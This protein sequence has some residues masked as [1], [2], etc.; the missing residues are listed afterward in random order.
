MSRQNR[1]DPEGR[2]VAV[3]ARG[4]LMGNRGCLHDDYGNVIRMSARD[5]WVTCLLDF[6]DRQRTVMQPGHYTELFFLDEATALAAGHRPC[7]EC[8]RDRYG[9]YLDAWMRALG[10]TKRP[11]AKD[12]DAELKRDRGRLSPLMPPDISQL[13]AGSCLKDRATGDFCMVAAGGLV[14]WSFDGYLAKSPDSAALGRLEVVTPACHVA[15]LRA[16]YEPAFHPS[17]D[18]V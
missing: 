2:L 8:R 16:G 7:A 13:P 17:V 4:S 15:V 11:T 10:L 9:A 14:R 12:V 3:A 18:L 1:V 6:K 5:A